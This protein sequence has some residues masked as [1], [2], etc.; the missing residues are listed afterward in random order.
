[1]SPRRPVV[2]FGHDRMVAD[3]IALG[4]RC[5]QD[6]LVHCSLRKIGWVD[7]G[8]ATVLKAL[9]TV[10]GPA[11]TIVVPTQTALS[12]PTSAVFREA[13]VNLNVEQIRGFVAALPG[14]DPARTP[15][16]GMGAFAEHVRTR[17]GAVR[18]AHPLTSFAA[19]GPGA[20]R[21]MAGHDL[22][23]LLGE[24]SP[25]GRLYDTDAAVLQLGATTTWMLCHLAE[26][27][28]PGRRPM[29]PYRCFLAEAGGRREV[30]FYGV[31]LDRS[32]FD[33]IAGELEGR[34]WVRRGSV[35]GANCRLLGMRRSVDDAVAQLTARRGAGQ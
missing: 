1:M 3:L 16:T 9:R 35:G 25:L 10:A 7:G 14:F 30:S 15:S 22:D 8:P 12:S 2:P 6:L 27:R 23:C 4:V 29:R 13:T 24:R 20:H 11:A 32:D 28:L 26:Y 17:P 31:A 19:L 21:L 5:G 18:S 33:A 34:I